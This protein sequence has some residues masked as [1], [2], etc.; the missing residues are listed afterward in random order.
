VKK[1][2]VVFVFVFLFVSIYIHAQ[3]FSWDINFQKGNDFESVPISQIIRVQTGELIRF[4]VTSA[5]NAYCYIIL[6]D[7]QRRITVL[8]NKSVSARRENDFGPF[9]ITDPPG[10]ETIYVILSGERQTD[11]ERLI[12]ELNNNPD[13]RQI[14]NNLYREIVKMQNDASK[15]GEPASSY[16]PSG[17][18]TRGGST[19]GAAPAPFITRFSG[20]NLYV[21]AITIR[22]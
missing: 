9:E 13:S 3:N 4:T 12:N 19:N 18:T 7:S 17:G 15:L 22:H 16:I 21:K 1:T 10:T 8:H 11:L 14:N 20:Y 5:S 2:T 6:Y